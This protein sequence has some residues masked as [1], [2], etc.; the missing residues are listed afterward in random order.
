MFN[1]IKVL[2]FSSVKLTLKTVTLFIS[3]IFQGLRWILLTYHANRL[4][5]LGQYDQGILIAEQA[6]KLSQSFG[7][8]HV[9]HIFAAVSLN[10]LAELYRYQGRYSEAEP[11]LLQAIEIDKIALPTNHPDFAIHLNNLAN[12][13][14]S[15]GR[16]SEAEPLYKQAIEIDK[17]ALPTNH[18]DFATHLNNLAE[19]YH[20]QGR[21]LE[22]ELLDNS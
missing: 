13:Y 22:A 12:I 7:K 17:I 15:Q 4:Y 1:R 10:N 21:Y 3:G 5:K 9:F 11:L 20:S 14:N 19:L 6:V 16:Y 18:P 8:N 2:I